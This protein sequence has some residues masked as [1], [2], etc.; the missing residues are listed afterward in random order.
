MR[1]NWK[2]TARMMLLNAIPL[3]I[4]LLLMFLFYMPLHVSQTNV[5]RPTIGIICVYYWGV[6]RGNIFGYFSAFCV[7]FLTDIYSSSPLGTNVLIM[8]FLMFVLHRIVKFVHSLSFC[9][10]WLVFISVGFIFILLKWMLLSL[11]YQH[12][13]PMSEV[14]L[15]FVSTV[16]FYP[17]IV[18]VNSYIQSLLPQVRINE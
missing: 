11:Y 18:Y 6:K 8:M 9:W 7:G 2:E 16:M 17:L 5:F 14:L 13:L 15:N 4:T 10:N 1:D 3:L 12:F